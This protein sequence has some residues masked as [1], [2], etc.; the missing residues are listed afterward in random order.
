MKKEEYTKVTHYSQISKILQGKNM[1]KINPK[2][3]L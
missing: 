2:T 1:N 3:S